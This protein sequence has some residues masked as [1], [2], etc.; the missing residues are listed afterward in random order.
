[1]KWH[2][3]EFPSEYFGFPLPVIF[4]RYSTHIFIYVQVLATGRAGESWEPSNRA[5]F[6]W[7][8]GEQWKEDYFHIVATF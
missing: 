1:M 5:V 4:H 8:F 3:D 2:C 7:I 6:S